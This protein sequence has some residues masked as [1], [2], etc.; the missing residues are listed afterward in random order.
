[1]PH[2]QVYFVDWDGNLLRTLDIECA[3]DPEAVKRATELQDG[4][5]VEVWDQVRFICWLPRDRHR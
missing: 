5:E 4:H 2:Y 3:G 1:M